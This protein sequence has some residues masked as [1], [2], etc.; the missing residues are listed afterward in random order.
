MEPVK[1]TLVPIVG[2]SPSSLSL[3]YHKAVTSLSAGAG[4][5]KAQ[6]SEHCVLLSLSHLEQLHNSF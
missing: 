6:T 4:A 3:T 1:C 2:D 5:V